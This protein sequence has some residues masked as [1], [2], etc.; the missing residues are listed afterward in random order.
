MMLSVLQQF[1]ARRT[2]EQLVDRVTLVLYLGPGGNTA[3]Q[4]LTAAL[5]ALSPRLD[6]VEVGDEQARVA[7]AVRRTPT[8][9]LHDAVGHDTGIR[10]LGAPQGLEFDVLL[11]DL[12]T[13]SRGQNELTPLAREYARTL[14]AGELEVLVTPSCTRCS[15]AL[16]LAHQVA[17]VSRR[18]RVTAVDLTAWP[19]RAAEAGATTVPFYVWNDTVRFPGPLPDLVLLQRL[20]TAG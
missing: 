11:S 14:P 18:V 15:H 17:W 7:A 9:A 10:F 12:L 6:V 1:A 2:A 3:L 19:E 16:T 5:V 8:L 20:A 13:V 4:E